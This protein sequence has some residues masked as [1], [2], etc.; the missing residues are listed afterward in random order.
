MINFKFFSKP[1]V[2]TLVYAV[3]ALCIVI[4]LIGMFKVS[5]VKSVAQEGQQ[6]TVLSQGANDPAIV[7]DS[8]EISFTET[9]EEVSTSK[10]YTNQELLETINS[11]ETHIT[12]KG[13]L[14]AI[15]GIAVVL[16]I[17]WLF[18]T[19]RKAIKW[20]Y[21]F[22]ALLLQLVIAVCILYVPFVSTC[23]EYVGKI[24]V[25]INKSATAG[26]QFLFADF[27]DQSKS[28]YVFAFSI[29]PTIIFFSALTSILFH[30]DI[31]QFI[32]KWL[33][34][35]FS[36]VM[37]LTGVESLSL[38][39]NIFLGQTEAPLVVK[40]Y[41]PRVKDSE[42]FMVMVGGMA[43]MAGG[44]LASYIS[45]LGGTDPELQVAFA[46]HLL[47]A[48]VMAAPAAVV[49]GRIVVPASEGKAEEVVLEK[50]TTKNN[51]LD[52]IANGA[53]E[54]MRLAVNVATMLL[55]FIALIALINYAF[56]I[57]GSW[58]RINEWISSSTPYKSL[59][60]EFIV[61]YAMSPI[62]WLIGVPSC[63]MVEVGQLLGIKTIVNEFV[64]YDTL[65]NML[66]AGALQPK[67]I[68]MSIYI[69][70]G[71][72]NFSSIGIQI[73]GIGSLAPNKRPLLAKYGIRA[74][75]VAA[76]TAL[77]SAIIMGMLLG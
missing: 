41:L 6:S 61:G 77:L 54:G 59:S 32:V 23:I 12:L 64:G 50:E 35:F 13:I 72:A 11:A 51:I 60:L 5:S 70:C 17:A 19:N 75:I 38:A 16:F 47:T 33:G 71:F 4:V 57:I 27:A 20:K 46:K 14:R 8:T 69:L 21:V 31:I 65:K 56:E 28:G 42:I 37:G 67:S 44:V 34:K 2:K 49:I 52:V 58:T 43:T 53:I 48:S 68:I 39:G 7:S 76:S 3:S 66:A 10:T 22:S 24:F 29:L 18:S 1:L 62:M 15:L 36:K 30:W 26:I 45:M 55:V 9:P 74:L 25:Y 63:D 40:R 73:G